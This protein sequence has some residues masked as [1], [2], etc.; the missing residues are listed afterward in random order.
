MANT[1]LSQ[2]T[3]IVGTDVAPTDSFL[4]YD[5]SANAEKQITLSA[6][7]IAVY[8][9]GPNVSSNS[10]VITSNSSN[11]AFRITQTGAGN[12]LVVEDSANPDST[13]FVIAANGNVGIGLTPSTSDPL[14]DVAAGALQVNGN[15]E[16]RYAGVNTDPAGARYFNIVNTDTALVADQPLGGIQWV[17]LDDTNPNSNMASI[18]SYCSGN[19]G[20]TGDLRFKIAGVEN[21]R[22]AAN[23]NV[24]IGIST[25]SDLLHI[26]GTDGELLRISVTSNTS[27][28]QTFGLGF[29]T[30]STNVHPAAAI[31]TEEF[32]ASD[33]RA[34]LT[35]STRGTNDDTAPT[36][37]MRISSAGNVG[38]GTNAPAA[39]LNVSGDGAVTLVTRASGTRYAALGDSGSTDDGSLIIYDALGVLKAQI[40]GQDVS[41]FNGGDVGIGTDAPTSALH[42]VGSGFETLKIESTSETE[43]PVLSLINNNT[44]AADWTLRLDKSDDAKFQIRYNNSHRLTINTAGDVGIGTSSPAA[45]LHISGTTTNIAQFTASISGTTMDVTAIAAGTIAVG[46]IVYGTGVSPITRITALGTGTGSTGTYTVSVS[47]TVASSTIFTGS[48]T[49]SRIRISDTDV[50][51]QVGQPAGSIE[52]FGSD[53]NS[54]GAGIGAYISAISADSS[55]DTNLVFGTRSTSTGA[56]DA[57]ERMRIDSNGNMGIGTSTPVT[58]IHVVGASITTGVTYK[59]QPTQA[60]E[61]A[62]VTLTIA[63]LLTGIVQFTGSTIG[64]LTLPLGTDIE[65]G[66][67]ATFPVNMSFDFSVINT[68]TSSGNVTITTNTGLTLVGSMLVPI[69]T[70]GLFRVRKTAL[71]AYTIYR[72]C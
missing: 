63:E 1:T 70:S 40:R 71:N 26:N 8:S 48:P 19:A 59:N 23:G 14:T 31:Y 55:P 27:L 3:S 4:I 51:S 35:F 12:A 64:T 24:G 32:D 38:I 15:I 6:L 67:P 17:G 61:S 36:E 68:G 2:L 54:P 30:G 47:Q 66:L 46:D 25:P 57:N 56:V 60:S 20:T 29:A 53:T 11:S 69:T 7:R 13:P 45:Q 50:S 33:S 28:Q 43:D 10:F 41:Y 39:K 44:S 72:I 58:P 5:T 34:A 22:I 42:L 21:M 37:R 18:T 62:A 49:A 65:G 9:E 16:L 52:F